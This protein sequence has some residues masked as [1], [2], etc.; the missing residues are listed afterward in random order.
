M[1]LL[2]ETIKVKDG[3]LFNID[4]H[5]SRFNKSRKYLFNTGPAVDLQNKIIIPAYAREGLF[6]CRIEYDDHIRKVDFLPYEIKRIRTLRLVEAGNLEYSYKYIN[7]SGIDSLFEQRNGCDDI[8]I[9]KD[10]RITDTSYANIIARGTDGIW[11]TPSSYLLRGTKREYL[12]DRGLIKEKDITPAGLK[13]FRE[14][15]LINSMLDIDDTSS[16]P[17]R[18]ICF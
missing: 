4:Y 15:R 17:V 16:I 10:G 13:R 11:Y 8:L 3:R 6:K 12:L 9:I 2:V 14:L 18:T 7:R 5:S 1:S